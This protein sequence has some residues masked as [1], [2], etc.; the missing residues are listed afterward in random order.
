MRSRRLAG[1][2]AIKE[3]LDFNQQGFGIAQVGRHHIARAIGQLELPKGLRLVQHDAPVVDLHFLAGLGVVVDDHALRTHDAGA[4]HLLRRKPAHLARGHRPAGELK[5]QVRHVAL[6]LLHA[7]A[8]ER[9]GLHREFIQ[10]VE[11][12]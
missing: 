2:D 7:G 9:A 8:A 11:Q 4:A 10:P 3:V 1:F 12:N 5:P 6:G